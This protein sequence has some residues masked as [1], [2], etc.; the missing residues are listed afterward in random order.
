MLLEERYLNIRRIIFLGV[1][2]LRNEERELFLTQQIQR[3]NVYL[4][5]SMDS[6]FLHAL[7]TSQ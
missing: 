3:S 5:V 4:V 7:P 1:L 6:N 2:E